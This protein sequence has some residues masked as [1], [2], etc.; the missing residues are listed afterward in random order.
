MLLCYLHHF[1]HLSNPRK[2]NVLMPLFQ[3]DKEICINVHNRRVGFLFRLLYI[4]Y[5]LANELR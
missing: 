1:L 2:G 4:L 3:R 5:W